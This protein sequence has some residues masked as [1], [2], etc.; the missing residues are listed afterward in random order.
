MKPGH[1]YFV[2]P[3]RRKRRKRPS[4]KKNP[5]PFAMVTVNPA[6]KNRRRNAAKSGAGIFVIR[7]PRSS[8]RNPMKKTA[9]RRRN[10]FN[11]LANLG[12]FAKKRKRRRSRRRRNAEIGHKKIFTVNPMK[13]TRRGKRRHHKRNPMTSRGGYRRNRHRS[14]SRRRSSHRRNP[15]PIVDTL[16]GA[17]MLA[18]GAGVVLASVGTQTIL[19]WAQAA[20][21][22]GRRR[23][24]LPLV[25]YSMLGTATA[26]TFYSANAWVFAGYK[27]VIGGGA[28]WFLRHQSPRLARGLMIG[29]VAGAISDALAA[30]KVVQGGAL[31]LNQTG[32]SR[33][34]P[35]RGAG[36]GTGLLPGTNPIFTNPNQAFLNNGTNGLPRP[37]MGARVGPGTMAAVQNSSEPAFG[38]AN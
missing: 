24:S 10:K 20:G 31:V 6:K 38:G 5:V 19:N 7:G 17:D 34:W 13:K 37:G 4:A 12:G 3:P 25:D 23:F 26:N 1:K 2:N 14:R 27:L 9:S 28:G 22:D 8:K 30:T 11:P 29:A 16:F 15:M 36:R 21:N 33:M 35:S 32:V 18:T